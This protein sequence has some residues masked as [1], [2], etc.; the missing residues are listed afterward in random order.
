[1]ATATKQT[2]SFTIYGRLS[3]LNEYTLKCRSNKYAGA[4]MKEA[5]EQ[6]VASAILSDR[7]I[8]GMVFS[9]KVHITF[10]WYEKNKRR[11]LDNIAF[12]KKFIQD[13]LVKGGILQGDGWQHIVGFSDEFYIDKDNPRIEV[14][15]N[16]V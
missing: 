9:G 16:E 3:G 14:I 8:W 6:Q 10:K 2:A 13:A 5:N 4:K 12:A 1:M 15:I 11:D 7:I